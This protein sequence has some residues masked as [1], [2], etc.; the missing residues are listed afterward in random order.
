MAAT[1]LKPRLF[2]ILWKET[3]ATSGAEELPAVGG[4]LFRLESSTCELAALSEAYS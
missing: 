1:M 2:F 4:K 3:I